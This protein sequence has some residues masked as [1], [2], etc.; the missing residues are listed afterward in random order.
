MIPIAQ[1]DREFLRFIWKGVTYQCNCLPF[2]LSSAPY[3]GHYQDHTA[4]GS[5]T[6]GA[7]SPISPLH[8]RHP[9]HG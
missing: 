3:V 1:V 7:G 9:D 5:N 8:R 4:S 2:G 6:Q